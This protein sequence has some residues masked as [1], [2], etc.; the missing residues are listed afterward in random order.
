MTDPV[1]LLRQRVQRAVTAVH[2]KT[3]GLGAGDLGEAVGAL[4]AELDDTSPDDSVAAAVAR[5]LLDLPEH[6]RVFRR[7]DP[8]P[9]PEV[10]AVLDIDGDV[11][12]RTRDGWQM[13]DKGEDWAHV[14]SFEPLVACHPLPDYESAVAADAVARGLTGGGES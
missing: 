9:D 3:R 13:T 5:A 7:G 1:E 12:N 8:E 6:P 4:D 10:H 2:I 14:L 11:W